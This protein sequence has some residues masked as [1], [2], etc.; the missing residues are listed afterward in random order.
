VSGQ[1]TESTVEQAALAWL[2]S[3]GWVVKHGPD[4]APEGLFA[5]RADYH[6]VVLPKFIHGE[7]RVQAKET[8]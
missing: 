1:F 7:I 2:E 3:L 5:E 6:E 4:I 8:A